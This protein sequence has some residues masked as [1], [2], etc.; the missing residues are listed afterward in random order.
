MLFSREICLIR[1]PT[2]AAKISHLVK[3]AFIQRS[4]RTYRKLWVDW[5]VWA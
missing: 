1:P 3:V 5:K 2:R 4:N